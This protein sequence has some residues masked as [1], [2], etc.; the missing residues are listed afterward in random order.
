V[1]IEQ[2]EDMTT[3][4]IDP[5]LESSE[6]APA[7]S[8]RDAKPGTVITV[9]VTDSPKKIQGKEFGTENPATW[10]D[11]KPKY[12]AV[13]N[14]T[15]DG[16]PRSVWAQIPSDLFI[17]LRDAQKELGRSVRDGDVLHIRF[18]KEE[19]TKGSPKKIYAVKIDAGTPSAKAEDPFGGG[20][21]SPPW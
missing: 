20:D 17:K 18:V 9:H 10:P 11:G 7:I 4:E 13:I 5:F 14:G 16:E 15:V 21:D 2:G 1:T 3:A 8:F 19:P 6:K 12:S